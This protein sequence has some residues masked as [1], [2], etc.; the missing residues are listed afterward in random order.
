MKTTINIVWDNIVK[1]ENEVFHTIR[2]VPYTY[3]V[4][5]NF[6]LINNDRKR[7]ITKDAV[8][9]ALNIENPTPSKIESEGIWGPSYVYGIITDNRI[10]NSGNEKYI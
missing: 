5:E 10:L 4:K 9:K 7:K 2:G 6:V 3:V 8:G 1:N